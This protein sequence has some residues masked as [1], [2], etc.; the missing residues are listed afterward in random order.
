M[1]QRWEKGLSEIIA[2][3]HGKEL[4]KVM[5][6]NPA[7]GQQEEFYLFYFPWLSKDQASKNRYLRR[8]RDGAYFL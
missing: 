7:T 1:I 4:R 2:K 3:K 5:F 6:T 8:D